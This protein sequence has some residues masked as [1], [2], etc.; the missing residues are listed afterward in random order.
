MSQKTQVLAHLKEGKTI[1]PL[2]AL[3]LYGSMRLSAIIYDLKKEG[4]GIAVRTVSKNG[5]SFAEYRLAEFEK[6]DTGAY[7]C[8]CG[9]Y[10]D[11]KSGLGGY[12]TARCFRCG[13]K[14]TIK[15]VSND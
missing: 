14:L 3:N 13:K 2:E 4:V 1:T 10:L 6:E 7:K 11:T 9:G 8:A 12:M 5:K 15:E